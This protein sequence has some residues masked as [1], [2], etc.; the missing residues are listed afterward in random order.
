MVANE[1]VPINFGTT[2]NILAQSFGI[3]ADQYRVGSIALWLRERQTSVGNDFS[4]FVELREVDEN[5]SPGLIIASSSK[6]ASEITWSGWHS[7]SFSMED[8]ECPPSKKLAIVAWQ[9]GGDESNGI[10]WAYSTGNTAGSSALFSIDGGT[11]WNTH[12]SITRLARVSR[13]YDIFSSICASGSITSSV[14]TKSIATFSEFDE[15]A[16]DGGA[17]HNG[18][19]AG[20]ETIPEEN[21]GGS[22]SSSE[23][24]TGG[25]G[26]VRNRLLASIVIDGSGSMGWN[27]R[28]KN[29]VIAASKIVQKIQDEYP[30]EKLFD[31]IRFGASEIGSPSFAGG[32]HYSTVK[33]NASLPTNTTPNHDGST[34]SILDPIVACGLS[35]LEEGHTYVVQTIK[36]GDTILFDGSG[37][38]DQSIGVR[39][40]DNV[41]SV[42]FE[43]NPARVSIQDAGVGSEN[44]GEGSPATVIEIPTGG[45]VQV[46]KPSISGRQLSISGI[47][48]SIAVGA[49]RIPLSIPSVFETGDALDIVDANG[50]SCAHSIEKIGSSYVD[51]SPPS[52][53]AF[54]SSDSASGG[55][56]Q[57]TSAYGVITVDKNKLIEL[58]VKDEQST[59]PVVFFIQTTKGG[60]M[61]WSFSPLKEWQTVFSAYI[62]RPFDLVT[63]ITDSEGQPLPSGSRVK[64]YIDAP[65]SW[66]PTKILITIDLDEP[67]TVEY[68]TDTIHLPN[69]GGIGVGYKVVLVAN[70]GA[71]FG[72]Y[73]VW[74]VDDTN[75]SIRIIPPVLQDSLVL[76][77]VVFEPP[78]GEK[79][80]DEK[81]DMVFSAVDTSA[82]K[83]GRQGGNRL[84]SDKDQV[85]PNEPNANVYNQDRM[86]WI[87]GTFDIPSVVLSSDNTKATASLHVL[88]LTDDH[89][90]SAREESDKMAQVFNQSTLSDDELAQLDALEDQ[91]SQIVEQ[92]PDVAIED[93]FNESSSSIEEADMRGADYILSPLQ[94]KIGETTKF[95]S[96][97]TTLAMYNDIPAESLRYDLNQPATAEEENG[98]LAKRYNVF[99]GIFVKSPQG[100]LLAKYLMKPFYVYFTSPIQFFCQPEHTIQLPIYCKETPVAGEAT[101]PQLTAV[102]APGL[103]AASGDRTKLSYVVY[104]RGKLLNSGTM[105][106]RIF[107]PHRSKLSVETAPWSIVPDLGEELAPKGCL[108]KD[109]K[110][111][112]SFARQTFAKRPIGGDGSYNYSINSGIALPEA[113]YLQGYVSGGFDV[114]IIN[115]QT[116]FYITA[117]DVVVR[118]VVMTEVSCPDNEAL[119][120]VR[121]DYVWIKNPL[122]LHP[123]V[124]WEAESGFDKPTF[125]VSASLTCFGQPVPNNV[126]IQMVSSKHNK[127]NAGDNSKIDPNSH[128]GQGI[129]Q[130]SDLTSLAARYGSAD[131]LV[132]SKAIAGQA[133]AVLLNQSYWTPTPL[134]PAV[135]KTINGVASGYKLGPHGPVLMHMTKSGDLRGDVEDI[136]AI[137]VYQPPSARGEFYIRAPVEIEWVSK[138]QDVGDVFIS[139]A[140]YKNGQ[141]AGSGA[142]CF[143]DG[144]DVVTLVADAPASKINNFFAFQD[145]STF[146]DLLGVNRDPSLGR[147]IHFSSSA[148]AQISNL[149]GRDN[150]FYAEKPIDPITKNEL[151]ETDHEGGA[152]GWAAVQV[153]RSGVVPPDANCEGNCCWPPCDEIVSSYTG[154]VQGK[155][156]T[157]RGCGATSESQCLSV[158]ENGDASYNYPSITWQEPLEVKIWVN[159]K[160]RGVGEPFNIVR[161]G[162]TSTEIWVEV[163]FSGRPL[164]LTAQLHNVTGPDGKPLPMPQIA[165]DLFTLNQEWDDEGNLSKSEE[166][167]DGSVSLSTYNPWVEISRTSSASG[168]YHSCSV[169]DITGDGNITGTFVEDT[170]TI[171]QNHVHLISNFNVEPALDKDGVMHTHSLLSIALSRINPTQEHYKNICIKATASYDA[172]KTLVVRNVE[173]KVCTELEWFDVWAMNL[174]LT[175]ITVSSDVSDQNTGFDVVTELSH[176]VDGVYQQIEDGIRVSFAIN[177]YKPLPVSDEDGSS[178]AFDLSD[179]DY[180]RNYASIEVIAT[181]TVSDGRI[182]TKK[183]RSPCESSLMW[184]PSVS[185]DFDTP[186]NDDIY[187]TSALDKS[188]SVMGAS[189]LYDA[190]ILAA[191]RM[192]LWQADNPSWEDSDKIILILTDGCENLSERNI[193]Q[194]KQRISSTSRNGKKAYFSIMMFGSPS[195]ADRSLMQKLISDTGGSMVKIPIG[196]DPA[197]MDTK[198][199][200]LLASGSDSFNNGSYTGTIDIGGNYTSVN[201]PSQTTGRGMFS[202]VTVDIDIPSGASS[203]LSTRFSNN[204]ITWTTWSNPVQLFG[205]ISIALPQIVYRYMQYSVVMRGNENF[206]TPVFHGVTATYIQPSV[207]ILYLQPIPTNASSDEYASEV[208]L[209]HSG[210]IPEL[211]DIKYGANLNN[212][213]NQ[214]DYESKAKGLFSSNERSIMLTRINEPTTTT[215]HRTFYAINGPWPSVADVN[216][217]TIAPLEKEGILVTR[218]SYTPNNTVGSVSFPSPLVDG[219]RV[220]VDVQPG[221]S[222]R[223]AMMITNYST[224]SAE[225]DDMTVMFNK[226]KRTRENGQTVMRHPMGDEIAGNSTSLSTL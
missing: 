168:H 160:L 23:D 103:V 101:P 196:L 27:D 148:G 205:T 156:T 199:S 51:V 135:G 75:N 5:G 9:D 111:P 223:L 36:M 216:V 178:P 123:S 203:Y 134:V 206:E 126:Q 176:K 185:A 184:T 149:P 57:Q 186:T 19:H 119:S 1:M 129:Q 214:S 115:G 44:E 191:D 182:I 58:S 50:V 89:L 91:Y 171:E 200:E 46:R 61:E 193:T 208:V 165:M 84:P 29:K 170:T 162:E 6:K 172:S 74:E 107:D 124:P 113:T 7:F 133:E 187:I 144:W 109:V 209:T 198:V 16:Q 25:V 81:F 114:D 163:N 93:S 4:F 108:C 41:Q 30:G 213:I 138:K 145:Q 99:P 217:Y 11:T 122:E 87:N 167:R 31:F 13:A 112:S 188:S 116:S 225:I 40:P 153:S 96:S 49:T 181:A 174:S 136:S 152:V 32:F 37:I 20:T 52:T 110:S 14:A 79:S 45:A 86:K 38:I 76:T 34:P 189:K 132:Y 220:L 204:G 2:Q 62:D 155:F 128:M 69:V 210:N 226:T 207:D 219:T 218:G 143:S 117:P 68:G 15:S 28:G 106:V 177:A 141:Y 22:Q 147:I 175:P 59:R 3:N 56:A 12:Q 55:F 88:P 54:G 95:T 137:A 150:R 71:R 73:V 159:G 60:K 66:K 195:M 83:A 102:N 131:A 78:E 190:I 94:A 10:A 222:I 90:N 77:S 212:T 151:G 121:T 142:T 197:L 127:Y 24:F 17:S 140:V 100:N 18:V 169:D 42:G 92:Q 166:I 85:S 158:D 224:A 179:T 21:S 43:D 130:L 183:V 154:I 63:Y 125:Q 67:T 82:L 48:D 120:C 173:K 146:D 70:S 215:N 192:N 104:N 80:T 211:A 98:L 194:V 202:S 201:D 161:D 65:P 72:G 118:L 53:M 105:R 221:D 139:I 35:S 157:I 64:Y 97:A 8:A 47:S 180:F 164:P 26:I 39:M 33:L